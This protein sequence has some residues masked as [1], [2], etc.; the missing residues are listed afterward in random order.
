MNLSL[1][2]PVFCSAVYHEAVARLPYSHH[3]PLPMNLRFVKLNHHLLGLSS[4]SS[5]T[6]ANNLVASSCLTCDMYCRSTSASCL[7]RGGS[8]ICRT[9][10]RS[11]IIHFWPTTQLK[12]RTDLIQRPRRV[13]RNGKVQI[14]RQVHH[15]LGRIPQRR[16]GP[17]LGQTIR[18]KPDAINEQAV[19]GA[20]DL[21]VAE[22][23]VGAE[24]GQHLVQ[25]VVALRV[26]VGRQVRRE[27]RVG[28]GERI[29][30]TPGLGAEREEREVADEAG[31]VGVRVEDG[32]VGLGKRKLD[33]QFAWEVEVRIGVIRY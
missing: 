18:D 9:Y 16:R 12:R 32:V 7:S 24:E 21:K 14:E 5:Y 20:L 22:E 26:G 3:S 8:Y 6:L 15:I 27:G 25:D 10:L 2:L 28:K 11:A 23:G 17:N 4:P 13:A 19:G 30:G 1:P 31:R 33:S 29:D